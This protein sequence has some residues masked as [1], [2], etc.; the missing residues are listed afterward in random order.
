MSRKIE[1]SWP[2]E[3]LKATATLLEKEEP[4]LCDLMWKSLAEPVKLFCRHPVSSGECYFAEGR[5]PRHPVPMGTQVVPLGKTQTLLCRPPPFSIGYS[6]FG[7]Y[8]GYCFYYGKTTEPLLAPGP[9]VATVDKE[10][11]EDYLRAAGAVW[12]AQCYT[13]KG[14]IMVARRA[15]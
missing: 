4:E 15:E 5:P 12:R 2:S 7:A 9:V 10:S 13:H 3:G 6:V 8:G 11:E 1:F 14:M